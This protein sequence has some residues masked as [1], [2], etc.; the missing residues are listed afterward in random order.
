MKV[1][2]SAALIGMSVATVFAGQ[3]G[4]VSEVRS[5]AATVEPGTVVSFTASG[6]NPCGAVNL[7]FGDGTVVTYPISQLPATIQ[8]AFA[9]PGSYQVIARGMGNCDG[10]NGRIRAWTGAPARGGPGPGCSRGTC[11]SRLAAARVSTATTTASSSVTSGP[12]TTS[13]STATTGTGPACSRAMRWVRPS[14]TNRAA[15]RP[16][17]LAARR[18][19][20]AGGT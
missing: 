6:T 1:H 13:R 20:A 18:R 2:L 11:R 12:G 8:H 5:S 16:K 14:A 9:G 7:N 19:Q 17:D 4:V 3:R 15:A 10:E